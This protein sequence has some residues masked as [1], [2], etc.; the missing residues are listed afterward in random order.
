MKG[1]PVSNVRDCP[2]NKLVLMMVAKFRAKVNAL[3]AGIFIQRLIVLSI[4]K[5]SPKILEG[6]GNLKN[7]LTS[8]LH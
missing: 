6:N 1:R 5:K 7:L 3:L 8:N 2:Y 4:Y